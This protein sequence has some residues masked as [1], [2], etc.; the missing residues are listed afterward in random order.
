[1]IPLAIGVAIL[2]EHARLTCFETNAPMNAAIG[3]ADDDFDYF[4][5][6]FQVE[7]RSGNW[8]P[9]TTLSFSCLPPSVAAEEV[10]VF[11]NEQQSW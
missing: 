2:D 11:Y 9:P 10:A 4:G 3:T 5:H 6:Y 8:S 7:T 1:M